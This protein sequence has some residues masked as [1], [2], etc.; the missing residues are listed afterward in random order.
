MPPAP[1]PA[2]GNPR[3]GDQIS[4]RWR[5]LA[6]ETAGVDTSVALGAGGRI[7]TASLEADGRQ[8]RSV[9]G[10][11]DSLLSEAGL[12]A[13]DIDAIAF[14]RGPGRFIGLRV[15]LA[16]AQGWALAHDLPLVPVSSLVALAQEGWRRFGRRRLVAALDAGRGQ[17]YSCRCQVGDEGVMEAVSAEELTTLDQIQAP[18]EEGWQ[19]VGNGW[20]GAAAKLPL[21]PLSCPS[22]GAVLEL[23]Y[24][25]FASGASIPLEEAEPLYLRPAAAAPAP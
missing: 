19:G 8:H 7:L 22:A 16:A 6:L 23:G 5:L 4:P 3:H 10:L 15:G 14:D 11:I 17:V 20:D 13:R 21:L 9:P 12:A 1:H 2:A 24:A 18:I 25:G